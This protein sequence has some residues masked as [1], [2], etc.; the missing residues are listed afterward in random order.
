MNLSET[1]KAFIYNY[2]CKQPLQHLDFG[3]K[4]FIDVDMNAVECKKLS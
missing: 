1:F 3:S 2:L 4:G